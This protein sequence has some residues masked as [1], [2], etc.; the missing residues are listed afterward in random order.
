MK[1]YFNYVGAILLGTI[2][3]F[4]SCNNDDDEPDPTPT[5]DPGTSPTELLVKK[6]TAAPDMMLIRMTTCGEL[7]KRLF[8]QPRFLL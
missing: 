6:F 8:Q 1:K 5:P 2:L 4:G 3:I 7:P